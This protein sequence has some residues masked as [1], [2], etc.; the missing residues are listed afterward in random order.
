MAVTQPLSTTLIKAH[1]SEPEYTLADA[2]KDILALNEARIAQLNRQLA[3][4]AIIRAMLTMLNLEQLRELR[5]KYDLRVLAGMEFLEPKLQRPDLWT[6]Y[7]AKI[8]ELIALDEAALRADQE[9]GG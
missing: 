7:S 5:E 2:R 4:M 3:T 1:M 9:K 6:E 8:D